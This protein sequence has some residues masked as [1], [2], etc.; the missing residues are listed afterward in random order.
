I[1]IGTPPSG[2]SVSPSSAELSPGRSQQFQFTADAYLS[3][4][5]ASVT[6]TGSSGILQHTTSLNLSITP[7][8][9]VVALPRTRY[10]RTDSATPYFVW[11]NRNWV[12]FNSKTNRFF[13]TD[14]ATNRV[15]VM[16]ASTETEVGSI[17]VPGAV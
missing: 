7:Y 14:P 17:I 3:A 12:T 11:P 9:G 5:T 2:V 16:D 1:V 15:I 6:V 8:G 10:V 4:S 13:V